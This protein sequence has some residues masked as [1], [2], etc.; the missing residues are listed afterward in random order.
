MSHYYVA[1]FWEQL[2]HEG[3]QRHFYIMTE[4]LIISYIRQRN[5]VRYRKLVSSRRDFNGQQ[6][7]LYLRIKQTSTR[8]NTTYII[9]NKNIDMFRLKQIT[10]IRLYVHKDCSCKFTF[11][12]LMY[13]LITAIYFSR[14]MKQFLN[15]LRIYVAFDGVDIGFVLILKIKLGKITLRYA[16]YISF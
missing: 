3:V 15:F 6:N 7:I 1:S 10:I 11:Y 5:N 8:S 9:N 14:N 4:I 13:F 2:K 16:I 12:F